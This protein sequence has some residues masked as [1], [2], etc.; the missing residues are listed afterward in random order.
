MYKTADIT[1]HRFHVQRK[2]ALKH[3]FFILLFFVTLQGT[4][5]ARGVQLSWKDNSDD[6]EGFVVERTVSADCAGGWEVIGYTG[7]NQN[8]F[9]DISYIPGACYRVAAYHRQAVST[10]TNIIIAP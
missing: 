5:H 6:E 3:L 4:A 10:Y 8:Y 9:D 1:R 2:I 7:R